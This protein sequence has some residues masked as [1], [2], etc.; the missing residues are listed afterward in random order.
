MLTFEIPGKPARWERMRTNG[1]RRF[2][3][4][5]QIAA[6]KAIQAAALE[7]MSADGV[8]RIES[9]PV[10]LTVNAYWRRPKKRPPWVPAELWKSGRVAPRPC[11]PDHDN[12]AKL[13]SDALNG[14]AYRDD[15]QIT[16]CLVSKWYDEVRPFWP[17][18]HTMIR[19]ESWAEWKGL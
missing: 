1:K 15:A 4:T 11:T 19:V 16:S 18:G 14:I 9:G 2:K 7:A 17:G 12:V 10:L 3:T 6:T 13:I 5:E 8:E